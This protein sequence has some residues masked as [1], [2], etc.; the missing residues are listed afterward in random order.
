M[1]YFLSTIGLELLALL[2]AW[3]QSLGGVRTDEAKVLL[4][5]PY[6][7]P[8]LLRWIVNQT[9]FLP[10]QEMLWRVLLASI[11]VQAVW[12][13]WHMG[14]GLARGPRFLACASWLCSGAVLLQ[15]GTITTA[16]VIAV[17]GL[18]FCWFLACHPE[19]VEGRHAAENVSMLRR[20]QHDTFVPFVLAFLWLSALFTAYQAVLYLPLLVAIL[21]RLRVSRPSLFSVVDVPLLLVI[22]YVLSNPLSLDRFVDAG[23][24]NAGKNFFQKLSELGGAALVGGSIVGGIAGLYGIVRARERALSF[25]LLLVAAFIFLSFRSYY[26]ILFM[27]LFT[28]GVI[29]LLRERPQWWKKVGIAYLLALFILRPLPIGMTPSPARG[30][31]QALTYA[32]VAGDVL[33]NG[34]FGHEWQYESPFPVRKY[35][36]EFLENAGVLV[37]LDSCGNIPHSWRKFEGVTVDVWVR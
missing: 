35:R 24:L 25:S 2:L 34:S 37:C 1:A 9:E 32:G 5:I 14:A 3:L 29:F 20:V 28:G 15:A 30:V 26:A 27:P 10:F 18:I 33:I 17:F 22:L 36:P 21:L 4:N 23:T 8:P 16:P 11:V 12:F 31:M 19:H 13:V 7:H 6:P